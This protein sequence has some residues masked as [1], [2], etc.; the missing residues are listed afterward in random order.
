QRERG[1]HGDPTRA[2][3][4]RAHPA[5]AEVL[6][7]ERLADRDA[8]GGEILH[9]DDAAFGADAAHD[10]ARDAPAV[11]RV[12]AARGELAQGAR[13][14]GVHEARADRDVVLTAREPPAE[15]RVAADRAADPATVVLD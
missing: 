10:L 4:R 2:R 6:G 13:L 12:S 7:H 9:R 3:R 11:E 1:E 15:H 5:I 8:I 14:L